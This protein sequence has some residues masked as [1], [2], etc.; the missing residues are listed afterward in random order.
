MPRHRRGTR[1]A[2]PG[3]RN[4]AGR[5]CYAAAAEA[6]GGIYGST[7]M[8]RAL[9]FTPAARAQ[10]QARSLSQVSP[11]PHSKRTLP[12][13]TCK[14]WLHGHVASDQTL[15]LIAE[16]KPHAAMAIRQARE[17]DLVKAL[18]VTTSDLRFVGRQ[19][20][21]LSENTWGNYLG[22]LALGHVN[23]IFESRLA[24]GLL[25]QGL[26]GGGL[27]VLVALLSFDR[28]LPYPR[29]STTARCLEDA[30][31]LVLENA[32][33]DQPEIAFAKGAITETW[34]HRGPKAVVGAEPPARSLNRTTICEFPRRC[35]SS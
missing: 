7:S 23:P 16:T 3:A 34:K 15:S 27:T 20:R 8:E 9:G 2:L 5:L 21:A 26:E 18:S 29:A 14:K 1:I 12:T 25:H 13:G 6:L 30:F 4:V 19:M 24:A 10:R 31:S 28:Q 33:K 32:A 35:K 11:G 17:S 22:H